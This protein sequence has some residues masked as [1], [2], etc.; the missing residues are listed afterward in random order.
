MIDAFLEIIGL[1]PS[2]DNKVYFWITFATVL[3]V[4]FTIKKSTPIVIN[5]LDKRSADI[6]DELERAMALREEAQVLLAQYQKKQR[7]SLKEAEE[8]VQK[9]NLEARRI[10]REAEQEVEDQLKK[11]MKLAMGKI[12][13]AERHALQEVQEHVI[14][15]TVA[16]ARNI[17]ESKLT[18][19]AR[20]ELIRNAAQDVQKKLH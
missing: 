3:I 19:A 5:A 17:V 20:E 9:A 1:T 8:I 15:I 11:R 4:Y 18:P 2:L 13:L 12:E 14:D 7:E 10:T 16:A 6:S